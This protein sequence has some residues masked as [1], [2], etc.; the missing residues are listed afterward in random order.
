MRQK[1]ILNS[2]IDTFTTELCEDQ[3]IS[4]N[5]GEDGDLAYI[6]GY[7]YVFTTAHFLT[8]GLSTYIYLIKKLIG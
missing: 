6:A 2:S 1:R 5:G 7:S 8:G 4:V 3:L